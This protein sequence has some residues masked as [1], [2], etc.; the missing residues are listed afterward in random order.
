MRVRLLVA[1]A[2]LALVLVVQPARAESYGV[3]VVPDGTYSHN[4]FAALL[5]QTQD[6]AQSDS[7]KAPVTLLAAA[8]GAL[9]LAGYFV[10]SGGDSPMLGSSSPTDP[11]FSPPGVTFSPSDDPSNPFIPP[12]DGGPNGE[13]APLPPTLSDPD[14][15]LPGTTAPE[16]VTMGLL[17]TGLAG[18]GGASLVRRRR[19]R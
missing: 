6:K 18:M 4:V 2:G 11:P 1:L 12:Q 3:T 7:T 8:G 10:F 15:T 13:P 9:G 16:P 14:P 17:A 19:M 5:S